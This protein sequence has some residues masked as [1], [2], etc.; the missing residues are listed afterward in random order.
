[1]RVEL[2]ERLDLRGEPL[3]RI[4]ILLGREGEGT[5]YVLRVEEAAKLAGW[6]T[7]LIPA[8]VDAALA[9]KSPTPKLPAPKPQILTTGWPADK[10]TPNG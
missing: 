1:M 6:I 8:E 4:E 2:V 5:V 3:R 10:E 9:A 7:E